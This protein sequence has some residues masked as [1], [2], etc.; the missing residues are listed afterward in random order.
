MPRPRTPGLPVIVP[1]PAH[2]RPPRRVCVSLAVALAL[3]AAAAPLATSLHAQRVTD[4]PGTDTTVRDDARFDFHD[5]GPYRPAVPRPDSLLAYPIGAMNTQYAEQQAALLA[6]AAA[7]NDRV[8]V[9]AF[10]TTNEGRT[11][12]LF[13]V[14][15]PENVAR[16]DAIRADLQAIADPRG[17]SPAELDAIVARTPAVV[18]LSFSVHGNESPGF[19]AV[20]PVLYQLAASEEPATLEMLRRTVV[21]LNPSSNPDGHERFA[22]WYNSVSVQDPEP[23]SLEHREPWSIQGRF[24]HYRFDMNRDVMASTQREVQGILAA[25]HRWR[26]MVAV[27]LHGMTDQYF[28]PPAALPVNPNIPAESR[29]WLDPIGRGNAAAFDR[30]GWLYYVRDVFDLFYPG[31]WDTW[32]S[33]TGATGMTYETDGGGWK[34]VLWRRD[35]GTLLSFRDGIAKHHVAALATI[36]TT[37]A[38]AEARVRDYL[39]ARQGAVAAGARGPFRRVV[40][41]AGRDPQRAAELAAALLRAGIEVR[42]TTAPYEARATGYAGGAPVAAGTRRFDAGAYVVDLAQPQGAVARAILEPSTAVDSAFAAAQVERLRRNQQ[43]GAQ[44]AGERYEFYDITAWS[45]PVAFGVETF[46]T[47]DTAPVEGEALSVPTAAPVRGVPALDRAA[48][49]TAVTPLPVTITGGVVEG[50]NA[51]SAYLFGPERASAAA[52]A[53]RLLGE[54]LRVS[55]SRR[56]LEAGGRTWPRGTYVVRTSRNDSTVHATVDRLARQHLVEVRGVNTAYAES[57]QYGVGSEPTTALRTPRIA[58]AGGEGISQLA[59]G[60]VWWSLER[61]YGLPFTPVNLDAIGALDDHNV[62]VI[63]GASPAALTRALGDGAALRRWVERGG[64]L[65]TMGGATTWAARENVNLTSARAVT[66]DSA[67]PRD[68][69]AGRPA[70]GAAAAAHP[71]VA[72]ISPGASPDD[73][74]PVPGAHFDAR[75]DRTHWLTHGYDSLPTLTA[76]VDGGVFLRLSREGTNVAVFPAEGPIHR[77]GFTWPGNTERLLRNTALVIEEPLG[78][79]RVVLFANEPMFRGW[80]RA[81]DGLVLNAMVL[82]PGM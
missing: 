70:D 68:T 31:Y 53:A 15:A 14:S 58:L 28:F 1:R 76:L 27:D 36:E 80:W 8:H 61:R 11:M 51:R 44:G 2:A 54:G 37:A 57:G 40:F 66:G 25:M 12:R 82:G 35:D 62:L 4:R 45:L 7:A 71:L 46:H 17:R 77:A 42:R 81:L 74:V 52:L 29:A 24:N 22:V 26:P 13:V 47:D 73:P 19:E 49:G 79:G 41:T 69:T 65:V 55:V 21:V 16:L 75:L 5:R 18:M 64:T 20:M 67:P 38:N 48:F 6:I 34:G 23:F 10:A 78:A 63:P 39:R 32:P 9:E 60:A 72:A 30:Y 59:Y 43:R 56:P 33:L 50:A 3:L